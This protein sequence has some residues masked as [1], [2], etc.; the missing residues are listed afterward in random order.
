[1]APGPTVKV[2]V[3]A[4]TV[5][6]VLPLTVSPVTVQE[7][8]PLLRSR[9]VSVSLEPRGTVPKFRLVVL[10]LSWACKVGVVVLPDNTTSASGRNGSLVRIC[11]SASSGTI[12]STPATMPVGLIRPTGWMVTDFGVAGAV[13]VQSVYVKLINASRFAATMPLRPSPVACKVSWLWLLKTGFRSRNCTSG[14][15]TV[16]VPG[17]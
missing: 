16:L 1:M 17:S 13:A 14:A 4:T 8:P 2:P 3:G 12:G 15:M 11:R 6:A 5:N 9:T 7:M 10:R